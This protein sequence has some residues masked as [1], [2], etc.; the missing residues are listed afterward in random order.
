VYLLR[1]KNFYLDLKA[2]LHMIREA[3]L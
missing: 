2:V 3:F 1:F